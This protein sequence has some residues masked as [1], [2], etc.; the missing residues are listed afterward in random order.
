MKVL[1]TG[2]TG[3]VGAN[4]S[5]LLK[6]NGVSVNYLS[7]SKEKL[8]S[9]SSGNGYYWN[10]LTGEIDSESMRDVD[11]IIHLAGATV[12]K[13]WTKEYKKE[14]LSSRIQTAELL[15]SILSKTHNKVRQLISASAIGIYPDSLETVYTEDSNLEAHDF[16]GTVVQQW[17]K[18]A[19]KFTALNIKVCKLRTGLVLAR[20]GGALVQMIKPIRIGLGAAFGTGKQIQSWIHIDDLSEMYFYAAQKALE[21][22]Y[23]AVAPNPVSNMQLTSI[24]A[25]LLDRP[26]ILP[27]IPKFAMKLILGEMHTLLFAS[28]N[29][30]AKKIISEGFQF[31]YASATD[32]L[33]EL[34]TNKK[35]PLS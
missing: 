27:K 10:P 34:L 35:A 11:I 15:Y 16:L 4:L 14:I 2:A 3:L 28:Q 13:R 20:E 1:I 17:E 23:N 7:T 9:D 18:S 26:L 8:A 31:K 21:G 24:I 25:K 12:A 29:V 32:A 19:D 33:S 30:S 6:N 22:T 5:A